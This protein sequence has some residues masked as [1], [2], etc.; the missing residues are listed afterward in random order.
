MKTG[1]IE[2]SARQGGTQHAGGDVYDR[3]DAFV[4]HARG[5]NHAEHTELLCS[6]R[7]R[8]RDHTEITKHVKA[9]LFTDKDLNAV[10]AG[11]AF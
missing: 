6:L 8:R 9:G 5:S 7:I 1:V 11:T 4:R 2:D 10:G 3:D